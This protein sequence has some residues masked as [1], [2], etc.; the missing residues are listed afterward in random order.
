MTLAT[1]RLFDNVT[2][3]VQE[4]A[5]HDL[6]GTLNIGLTALSDPKQLENWIKQKEN[7]DGQTVNAENLSQAHPMEE[8]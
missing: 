4:L 8:L 1:S 6:S 5:V 7:E 2:Y 3:K